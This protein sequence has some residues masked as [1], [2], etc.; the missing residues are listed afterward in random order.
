[1]CVICMCRTD[2]CTMNSLV[3]ECAFVES[4]DNAAE[5]HHVLKLFLSICLASVCAVSSVR[6]LCFLL[7]TFL[8]L[9]NFYG[10]SRFYFFISCTNNNIFIFAPN[11]I[12]FYLGREIQCN[13]H[14]LETS[15]ARTDI[16]VDTFIRPTRSMSTMVVTDETP[17]TAASC[18]FSRV[19]K[20]G[21]KSTTQL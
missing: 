11:S 5:K 12:R 21:T 4:V 15:S 18:R 8:T 16:S 6:M 17:R 14:F 20:I 2:K 13:S 7:A 9:L 10:I 1:M 19:T 3:V